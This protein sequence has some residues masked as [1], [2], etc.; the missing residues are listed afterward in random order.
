MY[1]WGSKGDLTILKL[2]NDK[3]LNQVP[4]LCCGSRGTNE[5]T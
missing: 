3:L 2:Q 4:A 5:D 1:I